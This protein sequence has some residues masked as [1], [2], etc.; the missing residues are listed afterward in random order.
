MCPLPPGLG[1]LLLR[2]RKW[3]L[4]HESRWAATGK[5]S[6]WRAMGSTLRTHGALPELPLVETVTL[7]QCSLE[8]GDDD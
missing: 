4:V 7:S 5:A 8:S 1:P 2:W 6:S 3:L